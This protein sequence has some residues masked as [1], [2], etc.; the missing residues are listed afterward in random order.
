MKKL[1]LLIIA[2]ISTALYSQNCTELIVTMYDEYGDGWSG[3]YLEVAGQS[4]TLDAGAQGSDT[5]CVDLS[6]CNYITV[7]GGSWQSEISWNIDSILFGGAPYQG[8]LTTV[9][10]CGPPILG[11]TNPEALNYNPWATVDDGD[12]SV[13][14]CEDGE[15]SMILEI[16]LDQYPN[17]TGWI[18]TDVS[19]GSAVESVPAGTYTYNQANTTI[20]YQVCVPETG[21][22]LILSDIYGDGVAGSLWGG[23]DGDFVILGDAAPCGSIDTLWSLDSA[24]F[25]GVAYSGIIYLP[26]CEIPLVYGCTDP[27]YIEFNPN[28]ILDDESCITLHTPGCVD[29]TSYNYNPEATVNEVIPS[30]DYT[31][32]IED[33][34]GD[35]WGES[36]IGIVQGGVD[37]GIYTMGPGAYFQEFG[38]TL[39]TSEPVEIYYFEIGSFQQ[40]Q[41]EISFQTMHNSFT[42]INSNDVVLVQGGINPFADNG[43]GVLQAYGPPFWNNYSGLPYCGDYCVPIVLG[44]VD[45]D[46]FNYDPLANT[47]DGE[48]IDIV[49]GCTNELAF[50]Y[51]AAANVDNSNCQATVYGCMDNV[52]WN[53]NF[54]ANIE[55]E[56][57]LYF[58]CTDLEALNYDE[59]ANVD[60]GACVYPVLGCTD[61]DAFN[62]DIDANVNDDSCIP[63]VIGCMDV[64]MFNYNSFANTASDNCIPYIFGCTDGTAFN[65]DPLSNTDNESCIPIIYGCTDITAFNYEVL[66]N[67]EDFS[68]IAVILGCTDPDAFNYDPL[69]NT[70]NDACISIVEGCMD[71]SADNY[72]GD[73]N[74]D[75]G[76]CLYDAGCVGEPGD[77]YWLND[78]CYAWV[79]TIDPYCCE[80]E[81]DGMCQSQYWYCQYD[82][83]LDI[84]DVLG[85]NSIAIYPNPSTTI[86]NIVSDVDISIQVYDV[87]GNL[88][89]MIKPAQLRARVNQLDISHLAPGIYNFIIMYDG[90]SINKKVVKQ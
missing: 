82:S 29:W 8:M 19:N 66:A 6:Q 81:W 53:Y 16:S 11:C 55:D 22:E 70:N 18:L 4:I 38:I 84:E 73:A 32:I 7:D 72:E 75:D 39:S 79:I 71:P 85:D 89:I 59:D 86:L 50:N 87:I 27:S 68:C 13:T 47:D 90:K 9:M 77:P 3:N 44:C 52:A 45:A 57:C 36:Y 56:S 76:S 25:G 33:D 83:P 42:L 60:N 10:D 51:D 63:V 17:E 35:G 54:L 64:T 20:P 78:T 40:L 5:V 43:S 69:A 88:V 74:T 23:V 14:T 65:F 31:L 67:T 34:G 15:A 49:L 41:P 62:F 24:N 12:C 37:I 58:G 28:A 26:A 48:C 80:K 21:V 1:L 61:P 46:A 30:C 2:S